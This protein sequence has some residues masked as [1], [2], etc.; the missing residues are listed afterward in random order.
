VKEVQ[1][2]QEKIKEYKD[3]IGEAEEELIEA[4]SRIIC[5]RFKVSRIVIQKRIRKEKI[6]L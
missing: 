1:K 2:H 6:N 4:I 3:L 5:G